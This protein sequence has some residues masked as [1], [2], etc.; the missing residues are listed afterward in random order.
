MASSI[1]LNAL[2]QIKNQ[3]LPKADIKRQGLRQQYQL[4]N[5]PMVILTFCTLWKD[6]SVVHL[7]ALK[8]AK[9]Q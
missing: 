8:A 3:L 7:I 4:L 5:S 6:L 9:N 1:Q 2:L